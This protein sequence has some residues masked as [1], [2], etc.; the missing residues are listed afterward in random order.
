MLN[1]P[2][3][4]DCDAVVQKPQL[5]TRT[6]KKDLQKAHDLINFRSSISKKKSA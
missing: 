3:D 4:E 6:L 2:G 1:E 5:T